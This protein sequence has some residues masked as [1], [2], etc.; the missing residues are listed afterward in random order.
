MAKDPGLTLFWPLN[1]MAVFLAVDLLVSAKCLLGYPES[2]WNAFCSKTHPHCVSSRSAL[3]SFTGLDFQSFCWTQLSEKR[4]HIS[5]LRR[6][7]LM[8]Q[9]IL[10]LQLH[11]KT[12]TVHMLEVCRGVLGEVFH[13]QKI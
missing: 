10:L 7:N 8:L 11:W 9:I 1:L 3:L 6:E 2:N 12:S 4:E 5:M 13:L